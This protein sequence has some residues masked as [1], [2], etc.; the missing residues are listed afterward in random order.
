MI[1][2]LTNRNPTLRKFH[3]QPQQEGSSN[4]NISSPSKRP[5]SAP[6]LLRRTASETTF[7]IRRSS[8][9][10]PSPVK[11]S[12]ENCETVTKESMIYPAETRCDR[13][14]SAIHLRRTKSEVA[15][16][17]YDRSSSNH[18]PRFGAPLNEENV[19]SNSISVRSKN[20]NCSSFCSFLYPACLVVLICHLH[21]LIFGSTFHPVVHINF[22]FLFIYFVTWGYLT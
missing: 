5:L 8:I 4:E 20:E 13:P 19:V 10:I 9:H 1:L 7:G 18:T 6:S 11:T 21:L 2:C 22:F 16:V 3:T 12:S 15:G 14:Q 17:F